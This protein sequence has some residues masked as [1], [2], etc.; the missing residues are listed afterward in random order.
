MS[1]KTTPTSVYIVE[2]RHGYTNIFDTDTVEVLERI[3]LIQ[4][5][6]D[7]YLFEEGKGPLHK[8]YG[9]VEAK[10]EAEK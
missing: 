9:P 2:G 10:R 3:G 6:R 4:H 7:G 1:T 8:F 5:L